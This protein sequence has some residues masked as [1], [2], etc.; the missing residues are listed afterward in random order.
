MSKGV[1]RIVRWEVF[2]R[3]GFTCRYCG[4][5]PATHKGTSL[6][7]DHRHPRSKGGTDD[8]EN[9]LT[10]CFECNNG[11]SDKLV[12]EPPALSQVPV[13]AAEV[14]STASTPLQ[15]F[16]DVPSIT[17]FVRHHKD[18]PR[19]ADHFHKACRCRKRL[20]WCHNG[21]RKDVS[22]KTRSWA[23]AEIVRRR[24]EAHFKAANEGVGREPNGVGHS[25]VF[26]SNLFFQVAGGASH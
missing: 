22:A 13:E 12:P 14:Q 21:E 2:A 6:E 4:R 23:Q 18:C 15:A 26:C 20:R 7:I 8:I 5:S 1:H 10:A 25:R 11:K 9:L 16:S 3:D 17:I 24:L 19:K